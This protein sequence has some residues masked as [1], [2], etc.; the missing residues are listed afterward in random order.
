MRKLYVAATE[1]SRSAFECE[2]EVI[3]FDNANFTQVSI[4]VMTADEALAG[5][6][7]QIESNAFGIPVVILNE[8]GKVDPCLIGRA[9]SIIDR[10]SDDAKLYGRQI[11]TL[12]QKYEDTVL[13]PFFGSL[14]EYV[15]N[16]HAQFDC[17]G[18]QG[19]AFQLAALVC[20]VLRP[21]SC[22]RAGSAR[23]T[24]FSSRRGPAFAK[25]RRCFPKPSYADRVRTTGK[26]S[27]Y[28]AQTG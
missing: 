16:G 9:A 18:H 27:Q 22:R 26:P 19:G 5:K 17:P 10:K 1:A 28:C 23:E 14:E 25:E 8:G 15:G 20:S 7:E 11:D 21:V 3:D 2:R 12:A 4:A 24:E 6:L 13:P